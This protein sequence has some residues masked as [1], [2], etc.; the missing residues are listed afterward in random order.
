MRKQKIDFGYI[1]NTEDSAYIVEK[2]IP[3][4]TRQISTHKSPYPFNK[5][6]PGDS[7]FVKLKKNDSLKALQRRLWAASNYFNKKNKKEYQFITRGV[8]NGMRIWRIS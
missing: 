5:M 8:K 3:I 1:V 6:K 4:P 7:F 2:K